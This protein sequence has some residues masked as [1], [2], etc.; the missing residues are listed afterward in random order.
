MK[1]SFKKIFFAASIFLFLFDFSSCVIEP[2][3][4]KITYKSS[5]GNPPKTKKIPINTILTEEELPEL[6]SEDYTFE[7]WY[8]GEVKA[9]PGVYKITTNVC[10]VA[11]WE[12][13]PTFE[14]KVYHWQENLEDNEYSLYR[15]ET[16]Y[17]KADYPTQA[18][19]FNYEGFISQ[20]FEQKTITDDNKT[21]INIYYD[22]KYVTFT[23]ENDDG[24]LIDTLIRKYWSPIEQ[25]TN[26][27]KEGFDFLRWEPELP[28]T[29]SGEDITFVAKWV[30]EGVILTDAYNVAD[31]ILALQGEGPHNIMVEGNIYT[32]TIRD[33]ANALRDN[34]SAKVN[35][36]LSWATN[37]T[38]IPTEGFMGCTNLVGI[39]LSD[40]ITSIVGDRAFENC[41]GLTSITIPENVS[42]ISS[43][44]TF[45]NCK[46][47]INF[48]VD[49]NNEYFSTSVDKAILYN[50]D[51]TT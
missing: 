47:L 44:F 10:F 29:F 8:D 45:N 18:T 51:K 16:L 24:S 21:E 48:N 32:S 46:N 13:I 9:E 37:L 11:K 33:I 31:T 26:L 34:S 43:S 22:R 3:P 40:S 5:Y 20:D 1:Y 6:F 42:Y 50:K 41:T 28:D 12:K 7:G 23:F 38:S 27:E 14:Y 19:A 35:L 39:I 49:L 4:C 36:D 15:T 25:P 30:L 2:R 17:G